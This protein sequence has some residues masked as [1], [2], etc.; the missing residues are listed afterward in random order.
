MGNTMKQLGLIGILLFGTLPCLA[1]TGTPLYT[2]QEKIERLEHDLILVQ[3]RVYKGSTQEIQ[4]DGSSLNADQADELLMRLNAQEQVINDLTERL[5]NMTHTVQQLD[6]KLKKTNADID[7][8]F[9]MISN[10]TSPQP[11]KTTPKVSAP[12]NSSL[13][14]KEQYE[15]A[16]KLL[17]EGKHI[18]AEKA[19]IAFIK[20]HPKD[21]LAG[22]ANYWLGETY[23]AR[24][25]YEMAAPVFAEGFTI[26]KKNSKAPDNLLKLGLTMAKLGKKEEACT[27]FTTLPDEFPKAD[28]NMKDRANDEAKKLSCK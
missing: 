21:T 3:Q 22:N 20:D 6:E 4:K 11:S 7:V 14:P 27:A 5:E 17:R 19:F 8:R 12:L 13:T 10:Q 26:Y 28:K 9:N 16:Y 1:Q 25:Q 18:E 23:Y 2:L 15:A 24:G